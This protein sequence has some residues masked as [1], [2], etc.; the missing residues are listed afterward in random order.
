[1]TTTPEF[2]LLSLY[3][4]EVKNKVDNRTNLPPGWELAEP[5]HPDNALGFSYGVFR[6][7]G[8]AE[9]V[10]AY[11]GTNQGVDWL[12][13]VTTAIGLSSTQA[14]QAAV[15]YLQAKALYGSN[16]TFTGHSLGGGLASVLAVWFDRPA[17]VFD[18]APF[19]LTA[20]NPAFAAITK[21]ALALAGYSDPAFTA[22]T[23]LFDF[24]AREAKVTNYYVSEEALQIAR[25]LWPTVLGTDNRVEFGVGN[26]LARRVDLHSQALL[27]A[28]LLSDAFRQA[29]VTVQ[30]TL[31]ILMD[32]GF[33]AYDTATSA[34]QNVLINF[35]R[36]EQGTGDKL[37]HFAA[38][39]NKLGT[40][41]AGLSQAAQD[42][43][44]AQS[45]EWYYWQGTGYAGQEFFTQTGQLLQYTTA[46]GAGL[47]NAK[48][49][50]AHYVDKWL[51]PLINES[52]DFYY[53]GFGSK[54]DQWN[55]AAGGA[56]VAATAITSTKSQI[57]IGQGGADTFTAGDKND[58]L[59]GGGGADT[60][61]GGA[62]NDHLY[63][64]TGSDT[65]KFTGIF[66]SDVIEDSDGQGILQVEGFAGALPQG[67]KIGEGKYQSVNAEVS[68]TKIKISETRTDLA[69]IFAGRPDQIT[70][71]NWSSGQ[72]GI[73]FDETAMLPVNVVMGDTQQSVHDSL[74]GTA[75]ADSMLGL[76]GNDA[77]SGGDGND[78]IE[79]GLDSDVLAGGLGSDVLNGGD[80]SDYIFGS[81][82]AIGAAWSDARGRWSVVGSSGG[83]GIPGVGGPAANDQGN[84][85]DAGA[86]R[87][88]VAAG[89]GNDVVRG[90]ADGDL[91]Y[92]RRAMTMWTGVTMPTSCTA[93]AAIR[94]RATT[95]P[96]RLLTT[97]MTRW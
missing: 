32:Q 2:A 78:V 39:L 26:M 4:Y 65:Y 33:Y 64:G 73:T 60:L 56:G 41:I 48:N 27:T 31:P 7:T 55:V 92:G 70:I 53:P 1:M 88:W 5:L 14:T 19:E 47:V 13:N 8:S 87:D 6:R 91:V 59:M 84:V 45:I 85:I 25:I 95:T 46:T 80:G 83:W 21:A 10:L 22:Y 72:F 89:T 61:N 79:G 94:L 69:L 50:S 40:N 9:I 57:Y 35:I 54:Y 11:A 18:E 29:T 30:R 97:A 43:I 66:G 93:T 16:I 82:S 20:R 36:S 68:Y 96:R 23:G 17:T 71:R 3:V 58:M 42:A 51:A 75:A 76:T 67:K 28:G 44:I 12:A 24:S 86:G 38:D 74:S 90:G 81:A 37:T 52:G 49:K 34:Q 77:L 62:G 63:G 15:A